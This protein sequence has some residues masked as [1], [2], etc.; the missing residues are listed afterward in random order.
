MLLPVGNTFDS[1]ITMVAA[2]RGVFLCPEIALRDR[3]VAVNFY[4][5]KEVRSPFELYAIRKK[6]SE[7]T[8]TVNNFVKILLA[9]VGRRRNLTQ[10]RSK[11]K[12]TGSA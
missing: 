7:Q 3:P 6:E 11:D 4:V 5:F 1:L 2:G 8:A 9:S 10:R 12:L